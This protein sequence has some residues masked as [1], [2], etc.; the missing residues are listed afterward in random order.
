MTLCSSSSEIVGFG[1]G[2]DYPVAVAAIIIKNGAHCDPDA[3]G[4]LHC[5][6][7]SALRVSFHH[8][9]KGLN[10]QGDIV[11]PHCV[12]NWGCW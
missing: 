10:A 11:V 6:H 3:V 1:E 2:A 7:A 8:L 4:F 12:C 5:A 9:S